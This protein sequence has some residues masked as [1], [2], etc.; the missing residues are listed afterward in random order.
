MGKETTYKLKEP[1]QLG[2]EGELVEEVTIARK[3]KLLRS[4]SLRA[5]VG[6]NNE[7]TVHLDF[8]TIIDLSAKMIG[9]PPA[10]LD[11][12]CDE[13]QRFIMGEAQGFLLGALGTGPKESQ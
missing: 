9:Q 7:V 6:S 3:L 12:M 13:D 8:G 2:A 4:H 11:E 5:G 1:V 10:L